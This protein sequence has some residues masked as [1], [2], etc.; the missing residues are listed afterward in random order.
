[1]KSAMKNVRVSKI[2]LVAFLAIALVSEAA[3]ADLSKTQI[4]RVKESVVYIINRT[5][6]QAGSGLVVSYPQ[7][8]PNC[9]YV[10]TNAHV[11]LK[12]NA[13]HT[14]SAK[15][16]DYDLHF[17]PKW[18][19]ND[20]EVKVKDIIKASYDPDL[21]LLEVEK[22]QFDRVPPTFTIKAD[23]SLTEGSAITHF[24]FPDNRG[25]ILG[26]GQGEGVAVTNGQIQSS[27]YIRQNVSEEMLSEFPPDKF[28]YTA[29][30]VGHGGSGGAI[31]DS[32]GSWI[33]IL[34]AGEAEGLFKRKWYNVI[35]RPN[36]IAKFLGIEIK[37]PAVP[38]ASDNKSV[39]VIPAV[40]IGKFQIG[41]TRNEAQRR[42]GKPS[43]EFE[44][45]LADVYD[46]P[47]V[48]KNGQISLWHDGKKTSP[49][50]SIKGKNIIAVSYSGKDFHLKNGLSAQ[51]TWKEIKASYRG[52]LYLIHKVESPDTTLYSCDFIGQG[53]SFVFYGRPNTR[54][55]SAPLKLSENS[56]PIEV[57]VHAKGRS[58]V[59]QTTSE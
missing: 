10:L 39:W 52:S 41:I 42:Y 54:E 32:A 48:D 46:Y 11:A 27:D 33:G 47:T 1:M 24:G 9:I 7:G 55:Y 18:F 5:A 14:M 59:L 16:A 45:I 4:N 28:F 25:F 21:A 30:G 31:F 23:A 44:S 15:A 53:I 8:N 6:Q 35:I 37:A 57:A 49:F 13:D 51:S 20:K 50:D 29:P 2:W 12:Q 40:G 36:V 38:S 26:I 19:R 22:N 43:Y 58:W 56:K 17:N 34:K 3:R